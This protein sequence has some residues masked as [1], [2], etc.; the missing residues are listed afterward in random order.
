MVPDFKTMTTA[1]RRAFFR[2]GY[3][4]LALIILMIAVEAFCLFKDG[5][6]AGLIVVGITLVFFF[7]MN[8]LFD[9]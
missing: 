1:E 2:K 7:V 4:R 3:R 8:K 5:G 9:W 6:N